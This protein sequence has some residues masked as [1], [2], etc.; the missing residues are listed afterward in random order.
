MLAAD[1]GL[2]LEPRNDHVAYI[3]S[4]IDVLRGDKRALVSAATYAQCVVRF[5]HSQHA[6]T[7]DAGGAAVQGD[8]PSKSVEAA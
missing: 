2:C 4:W 8:H 1:L 3:A 5:V 6:D 7:Q